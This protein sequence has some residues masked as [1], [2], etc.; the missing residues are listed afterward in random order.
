M[1]PCATTTPKAR[2]Q[3]TELDGHRYVPREHSL[4]AKAGIEPIEL[5]EIG[6]VNATIYVSREQ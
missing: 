2:S 3:L 6:P 5:A 4:A 1:W